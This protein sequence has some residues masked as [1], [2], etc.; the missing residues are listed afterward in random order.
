MT[1]DGKTPQTKPLSDTVSSCLQVFIKAKYNSDSFNFDKT[2]FKRFVNGKFYKARTWGRKN[3]PELVEQGLVRP[4]LK[5]NTKKKTDDNVDGGGDNN[6]ATKKTGTPGKKK[7]KSESRMKHSSNHKAKSQSQP[8]KHKEPDVKISNRK[9][10]SETDSQGK[11]EKKTSLLNTHKRD[12]R[13]RDD[14]RRNNSRRDDERGNSKHRVD[15]RGTGRHGDSG[16]GNVRKFQKDDGRERS[17]KVTYENRGEGRNSRDI[18]K[19]FSDDLV[20]HPDQGQKRPKF[21]VVLEAAKKMN[22]T[23]PKTSTPKFK[24][25][26]HGADGWVTE[27]NITKHFKSSK[28]NGDR[29]ATQFLDSEFASLEGSESET[30]RTSNKHNSD[31]DSGSERGSQSGSGSDSESGS[32]SGGGSG[33]EDDTD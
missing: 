17:S 26:H 3:R 32:G 9:Q 4:K 2:P 13:Q 5:K 10:S 1:C 28:S 22:A 16:S 33:S 6:V 18:R 23:Q 24:N 15:E 27:H 30:S 29:R 25:V 11:K 7:K 19:R 12:S 31:D 8:T 21:S 20:H 14:E